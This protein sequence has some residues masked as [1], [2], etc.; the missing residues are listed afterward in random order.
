MKFFPN[1]LAKVFEFF[2]DLLFPIECIGCKKDGKALCTDCL[3]KIDQNIENSFSS[4]HFKKV[5]ALANWNQEITQKT[6]KQLKFHYSK[7]IADDLMPFFKSVLP[8]INLPENSILVPIPLHKLRENSRGFNQSEI[9]AK[10]FSEILNK[11]IKNNLIFRIINTY[12]QSKL[13]GFK[14][15]NN[16]K[17]AFI[18]DLKALNNLPKNTAICLIDDIASTMTT[19]NECAL[20]FK[21][22]GYKNIYAI[23]FA[24]GK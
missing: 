6:I 23:V 15:R 12:P 11:P 16:L 24:R 20:Q 18:V 22:S 17:N 5:Y 7:K 14:R 2:V 1:K 10:S 3:N 13:K 21:R 8:S 4:K 9:L 19:L